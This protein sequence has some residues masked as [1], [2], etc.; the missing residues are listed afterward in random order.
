LEL[1]RSGLN[2]IKATFDDVQGYFTRDEYTNCVAV[3]IYY[4]KL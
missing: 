4:E 1:R 3:S 2:A